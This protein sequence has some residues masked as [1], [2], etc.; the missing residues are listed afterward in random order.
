[1][2]S[3]FFRTAIIFATLSIS[4]KLMGKRAIG[5]LEVEELVT[6]LLISEICSIPIDD[7]NIPLLNALIPLL[8]IVS[9]EVIIS[10]F[11]NKSEKL[12][13]IID[14]DTVFLIKNGILNQKE[15]KNNRI[16]IE[17]FFATLRQNGVGS[18]TEINHCVLEANG[19]ISVLKKDNALSSLLISDGEIL[20]DTLKEK[21]L[22]SN[23]IKKRLGSIPTENVFLMT[24]DDDGTVNI[25]IKEEKN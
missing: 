3:I 6:T 18:I 8:F 5:E 14:G 12:K 25:I 19:K 24:Y 10:F 22:D 16:S 2:A 4:M 20:N 1:M 11:K 23:W 9:C 21:G 13:R 7:P 15:L 17:E